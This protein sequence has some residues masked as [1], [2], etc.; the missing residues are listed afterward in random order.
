MKYSSNDQI[1]AEKNN[2]LK[3]QTQLVVNLALIHCTRK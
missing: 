2:K 3:N 1:K